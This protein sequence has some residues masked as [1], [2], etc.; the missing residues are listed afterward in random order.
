MIGRRKMS[1]VIGFAWFKGEA[2]NCHIPDMDRDSDGWLVGLSS[3]MAAMAM[4]AEDE[5]CPCM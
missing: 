5:L 1:L 2:Y 4:D 3:L